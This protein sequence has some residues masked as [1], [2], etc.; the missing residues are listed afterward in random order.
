MTMLSSPEFRSDRA[1]F[2]KVCGIANIEDARLCAELGVDAVGLLLDKSNDGPKRADS[3]R[4]S[5]ADAAA[6]VSILPHHVIPVLLVHETAIESVL[7][8]AESIGPRALQIQQPIEPQ[9]VL[10]LRAQLP[11]VSMI[12]TFRMSLHSSIDSMRSEIERYA[13]LGAIDAALLDAPRGGAG[14]VI[15]W[16]L[17]AQ[18]AMQL[19]NVRII[20]AGGLH[21]G[22]VR[23]A[24][25]K[26][27]PWGID[28]MTG[29]T[30]SARSRKDPVK[31]RAFVDEVR[32]NKDPT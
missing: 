31:L 27:R 13:G 1:T 17:S 21:A 19:P 18:I 24:L 20:L 16:G 7:H 28:V 26:V 9:D 15:D 11:N 5:I 8:L 14:Q 32:S 25:R 2:V 30:S 3:D 23:D 6:L 12:K 29:V 4:L 22:N 10:R